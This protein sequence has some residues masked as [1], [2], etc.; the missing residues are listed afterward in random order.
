MRAEGRRWSEI[1][2]ELD[3]L[4]GSLR[5]W[6]EDFTRAAPHAEVSEAGEAPELFEHASGS[7]SVKTPDGFVVTGLDLE[8][9]HMLIEMLRAE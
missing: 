4:E 2:E 7:L 3:V 5:R 9:A 8:S 6:L 1:A